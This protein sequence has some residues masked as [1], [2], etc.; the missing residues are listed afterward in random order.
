MEVVR[1]RQVVPFPSALHAGVVAELTTGSSLRRRGRSGSARND[2]MCGATK[3]KIG[4]LPT[5]PLARKAG[6]IC[7]MLLG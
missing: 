6:I 7:G 4:T 3:E 5:N 2:K 1:A